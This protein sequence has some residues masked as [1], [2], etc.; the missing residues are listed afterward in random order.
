MRQADASGSL[1]DFFSP[2]LTPNERDIARIEG[3]ILEIK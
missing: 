2:S 1:A 3:W